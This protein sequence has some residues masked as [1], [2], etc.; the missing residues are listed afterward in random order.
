V[1]WNDGPLPGD[2]RRQLE[3]FA[4]QISSALEQRRLR[5]MA[6]RREVDSRADALRLALLR[7][8]SHDLRTPL[9]SIKAS[10]TSL[11]DT[12]VAFTAA[13]R[14]DLLE[15]IDA[16]VDRLDAVVANLLDASRLEAGALAVHTVPA[17]LDDLVPALLRANGWAGAGFVLDLPA[18]LPAVL[19]DTGLLER[20]VVNLVSNALRVCPPEEIRLAASTHGAEVELRVADRGPGVDP[21]QLD[22]LFE[23]F[24]RLGDQPGSDG[25][26]LGLSVARGLAE[27][28]G[29]R[30]TPETTPGG[31]LTMVVTLPVAEVPAV[32]GPGGRRRR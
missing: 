10:A 20:V 24:Q 23:P 2:R 7:A 25:V 18:T 4:A 19:V 3:V 5:E 6:A 21:A 17:A 30:L 11:L 26:G 9:A 31:G 22:L 1:V 14:S 16:E 29:G 13:D 12:D 28:M 8:V 32:G 27:A 15:T